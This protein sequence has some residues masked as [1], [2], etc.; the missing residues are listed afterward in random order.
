[1]TYEATTSIMHYS[2][3]NFRVATL[4]EVKTIHKKQNVGE[5]WKKEKN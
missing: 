4:I 3:Y 2:E 5:E 1:M